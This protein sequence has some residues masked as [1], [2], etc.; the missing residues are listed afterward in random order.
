MSRPADEI[1]MRRA[2]DLARRG[3]GRTRPNP[4][5]GAVVVRQGRCVGEGFHHRA[6]GPHA[7]ILALRAAG[8]QARGATLYVTLE[9]CSTTGRTPPCTDALQ[10]AGIRRVVAALRD[11]NPAHRGRGLRLLRAAGVDVVCP[12]CAR[13]ARDLL[14]PFT[15][16]MTRGRPWVTLK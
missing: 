2:L 9:P 3:E 8:A 10:A 13:E 1:W 12:V 6:G 16:W 15:S 11:P 5:V 7:E 14:A 4:P